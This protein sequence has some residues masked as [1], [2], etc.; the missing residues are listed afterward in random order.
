MLKRMAAMLLILAMVFGMTG[1]ARLFVT[2][3]RDSAPYVDSQ[4]EEASA[5]EIRRYS[6]LT[7]VLR[8]MVADYTEQATLVFT[9]YDG[10]I[11]DD[12][13]KA[14]WE[15]RRGTALGAYC[16]QN[17]TYEIEQVVAYCEADVVVTY[18]RSAD[19]VRSI[20][21]A[22][23]PAAVENAMV[24]ALRSNRTRFAIQINSTSFDES[25]VQDLLDDA[26]VSN[27]LIAVTI[28][29][30]E[31]TMYTGDTQPRIFE[32]RLNDAISDDVRANRRTALESAVDRLAASVKGEGLE[33]VCAVC[34]LVG[35]SVE[36]PGDD[37]C[38]AYDV[39]VNHRGDSRAVAMALKAVCDRLDIPCEIVTGQMDSYFHTWNIIEIE[40]ER[41][42]IDLTGYAGTLW[43]H[44]DYNVWGRYWWNTEAHDPC[45]AD[46]IVW[47][48]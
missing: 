32:I 29:E 27:P 24:D 2:E 47:T 12:L 17:I 7:R 14:C 22:Q 13:A 43:F 20:Y 19:E 31:I 5:T 48:K 38:T 1:C 25:I 9:D 40:G 33:L 30:A 39:L 41:Y 3:Y 6:D 37:T 23:T 26:I 44:P 42:H 35:R 45:A 16:V 8:G 4:T 15:L 36:S 28:P 18:K 10:I 34:D 11:A 46:A 21:S